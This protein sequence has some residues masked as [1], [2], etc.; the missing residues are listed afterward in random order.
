[1][2]QFVFGSG[3]VCFVGVCV[4]FFDVLN[5]NTETENMSVIPAAAAAAVLIQGT[6][7]F[8]IVVE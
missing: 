3:E 6:R 2:G 4:G 1:M 7:Y 8:Q 5:R